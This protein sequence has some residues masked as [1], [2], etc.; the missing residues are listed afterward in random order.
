MEKNHSVGILKPLLM[1]PGVPV[2]CGVAV[3]V[4]MS[5]PSQAFIES[6]YYFSEVAE[7]SLGRPIDLTHFKN[8]LLTMFFIPSRCSATRLLKNTTKRE[9]V[10]K[11]VTVLAGV[12]DPDPQEAGLL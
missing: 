8:F 11:G 3:R 4:A 7:L 1:F 10:R 5:G 12:A 6:S 2:P 9:E